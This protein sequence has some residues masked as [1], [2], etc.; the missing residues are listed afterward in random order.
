MTHKSILTSFITKTGLS[1][2]TQLVE[3]V[4]DWA[5]SM[6]KNKQT[7]I[8]L[9]DFS[10]AFD[11]VPHKRFL[12]NNKNTMASLVPHY[13]TLQWINSFLSNHTQT[14]SVNG[15]HSSPANVISGVPQCSVLGPVLFLLY[16]NDITD[17]IN[18]SITLCRRF[19]PIQRN[20]NSQRLWH[21]TNTLKQ[22]L[23]MGYKVENELQYRKM[24]YPQNY[25][26]TKT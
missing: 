13:N 24:S 11:T 2:Q 15:S 4:H 25:P 1:C 10:K 22:T 9:L 26:K 19:R 5:S 14:V 8:L 23:R 12:N 3:A 20:S 6:N 18:L 7:D 17:S 16:I 21:P